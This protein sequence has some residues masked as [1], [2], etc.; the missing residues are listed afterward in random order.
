MGS[1]RVRHDWS[2]LA[3]AAAADTLSGG[4]LLQ[5]G[6]SGFSPWVGKISWRRKWQSTLVFL[7]GK[8]HGRRSLVG[9]SPWGRK[10]SDA[11]TDFTFVLCFLRLMRSQGWS[12][13]LVGLVSLWEQEEISGICTRTEEKQWEDTLKMWSFPTKE[14]YPRRNHPCPSNT[15]V[16]DFKEKNWLWEHKLKWIYFVY[17]TTA[18]AVCGLPFQQPKDTNPVCQR[19]MRLLAS[20]HLSLSMVSF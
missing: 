18:R 4:S 16:S 7:P 15:L 13:D 3:A 12:P 17:K 8:S 2:D 5:C 20:D 6:R 11:S 9:Y 14:R 19:G 1:H 10:E